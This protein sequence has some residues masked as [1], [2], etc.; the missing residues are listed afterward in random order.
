MRTSYYTSVQNVIFVTFFIYKMSQICHK[1]EFWDEQ[2]FK[3]VTSLKQYCTNKTL[4]FLY[5]LNALLLYCFMNTPPLID[6]L[7]F[8]FLLLFL[9]CTCSSYVLE[10]MAFHII[11]L[12][13]SVL[14]ATTHAFFLSSTQYTLIKFSD[15]DTAIIIY[16]DI[17]TKK[18][19]GGEVPN[20]IQMIRIW[21]V[22]FSNW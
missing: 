7:L 12:W 13:L 11:S 16:R 2:H 10:N 9:F 21:S 14:L 18:V 1:F 4:L 15:R 19:Q 17:L 20:E 5:N 3:F 8:L 6:C 22:Y